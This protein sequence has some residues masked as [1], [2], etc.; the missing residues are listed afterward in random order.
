MVD[1]LAYERGKLVP[2]SYRTG[3]GSFPETFRPNRL[4]RMDDLLS[5]KESD[6]EPRGLDGSLET[7]S[8]DND[9]HDHAHK[10]KEA[11]GHGGQCCPHGT[12]TVTTQQYSS[13]QH[14]H[15]TVT[16]SSSHSEQ[17]GHIPLPG[18]IVSSALT[19]GEEHYK[20]CIDRAI[21]PLYDK[22]LKVTYRVTDGMPEVSY[23]FDM[24]NKSE[25]YNDRRF[26]DNTRT[27]TPIH[28]EHTHTG[29]ASSQVPL[30]VRIQTLTVKK[31]GWSIEQDTAEC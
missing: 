10:G 4:Q 6:Y 11:H 16:A 24:I 3:N 2:D 14:A 26:V 12:G 28:E 13:G 22:R 5:G 9:R 1:G 8:S 20:G 21:E 7:S 18:S 29:V 27:A 31:Q 15:D 17:D 25:D 19:S 30:T 23:I